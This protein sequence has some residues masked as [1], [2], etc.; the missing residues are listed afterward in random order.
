MNE[1]NTE[2][3]EWHVEHGAHM[4]PFTGYDMP[5]WYSTGARDEHKSVLTTCGLF[6]T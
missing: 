6:D 4:A 1:N 5:L 2:L 3:H